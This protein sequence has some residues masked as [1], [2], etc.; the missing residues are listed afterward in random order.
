M[1]WSNRLWSKLL[2][3]FAFVSCDNNATSDPS[4]RLTIAAAAN[5]QFAIKPILKAFEAKTGI[6][7]ALIISS[8]G[9][10]TATIMQ[11]APYDVFLSANMKY[12]DTLYATN[13]AVAPPTKYARG[14]LVLWT[15][16][17]M[18]WITNDAL[19]LSEKIQSIAIANP[20]NAPYGQ[21]AIHYLQSADLLDKV[22]PKLVYG[23]SIAQTNQFITSGASDIGI[24]A[25]SVVLSPALRNKGTWKPIASNRYNPIDQGMIITSYG[26]SNHSEA[27]TL[28]KDFLLGPEAQKIFQE[29]G[30]LAPEN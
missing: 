2:L 24:T 25:K 15:M 28:F 8:S 27:A 26:Q 11:G 22:Q 23:E 12:P 21:E 13:W 9:K 10:H 19:L 16:K 3:F 18:D 1:R 6:Q 5:I 4:N 14:S 30:Y 29:Y 20:R 17:E 7:S